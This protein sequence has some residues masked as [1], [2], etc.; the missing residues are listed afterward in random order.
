MKDSLLLCLDSW[1]EGGLFQG[2]KVL[3]IL[4]KTARSPVVI[5]LSAILI[6]LA[7]FWYY[8]V[9]QILDWL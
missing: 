7:D 3:T 4:D 5:H 2:E 9:G 6:F 1:N 8:I